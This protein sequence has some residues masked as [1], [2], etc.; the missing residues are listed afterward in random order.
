MSN[1]SDLTAF[2][3]AVL[4]LVGDDGAGAHDL[5]RMAKR[6][7]IYWSAADSQ[8]Y[9]EPKRLARLGYLRAERRPGRT[10]ERT[11]YRLTPKGRDAIRSWQ[12][13]PMAFPR[14][15]HE[16]ITKF[17][18]GDVAD[19]EALL[20]SLEGLRAELDELSASLD[21]ADEVAATLPHREP[22]LR[23]NHELA[24]DLIDA[25]RRWADSAEAQL[26]KEARS[27]RAARGR[28]AAA[29]R[30]TSRR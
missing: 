10:R 17:L 22:Y 19:P 30:R 12:E 29:P 8:W 13:Q 25:H 23:I 27:R 9:A 15:Q 28:S 2:S 6:G 5:V 26:R 7:R 18:A 3:H 21:A 24:R 4:V 14:I 1:T 16:A 11:V 20:A